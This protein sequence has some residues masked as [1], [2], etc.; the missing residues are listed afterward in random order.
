VLLVLAAAAAVTTSAAMSQLVV[1]AVAALEALVV[2]LMLEVSLELQTLAAA[3][4]V[5]L[6]IV[7]A[8]LAATAAPVSSSSVTQVHNAA[9]AALSHHPAD[10]P[11][12]PSQRPVRT[13]HKEHTWHIL[14]K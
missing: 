6:A 8:T 11:I 13:P 14:Q 7:P 3:E 4:A 10:I 2:P 9:L 5:R 12:T 1:L